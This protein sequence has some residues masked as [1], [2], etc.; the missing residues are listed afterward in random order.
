[1]KVDEQVMTM[2]SRFGGWLWAR[3]KLG[4]VDVGLMK[5]RWREKWEG[6]GLWAFVGAKGR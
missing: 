3:K 6:L 4:D 1:M 2:L 5:C